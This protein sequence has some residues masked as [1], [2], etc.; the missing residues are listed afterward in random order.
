MTVSNEAVEEFDESAAALLAKLEA[1]ASREARPESLPD[2]L[3]LSAIKAL[4][5]LF[6]PRGGKGIDERHISELVR[7]IITHGDLEPVLVIWIGAEAYLIDGHHRV[8]AHRLAKVTATVPVRHFNGTVKEAVLEAGR[9]NSQAKLPM[10]TQSRMNFAWRLV[11]M[12]GY[13]KK[14]TVAASGVADRQVAV[15]RAAKKKLGDEVLK[16]PGWR[17]A[18]RA[19]NGND[20]TSMDGD[21]MEAWLDA[22]AQTYADRLSKAFGNK[23][24][25]NPELA[26]RALDIHF[27]R[28][29]KEV[30]RALDGYV[31][32]SEDDA[33]PDF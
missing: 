11:C 20:L 33:E 30:V 19:A 24:S 2:R 10:D 28:K 13:S 12:G 7:A 32:R 27:G 29:L 21:E 5:E 23:L 4:P 8:A 31:F 22:Q 3:A 26:A 25:T 17:L 16:Y 15:M 6:Q 1:R 18:Q 9:A 14:E